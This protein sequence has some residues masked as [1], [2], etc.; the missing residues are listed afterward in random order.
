[1]ALISR[2]LCRFLLI[3][4][5]G[6][7]SLTDLLLFPQWITFFSF[8]HDSISSSIGEVLLIYPSAN[9]FVFGDFNIHHKDW[10]VYS[11]GT[12]RS[13]ELC[14]NFSISN[15]LTEMVNFPTWIP[16]CDSHR[17]ILLD[18]FFACDA[19]ICFTKAFPPL[20]NSNHILV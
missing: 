8:V 1:M 12:D 16:D 7:T 3:I 10:H 20:G 11:S 5:A 18:L 9:V 13:G 17:P 15:Y 2:K 14:Y 4:S 19:S 6:F